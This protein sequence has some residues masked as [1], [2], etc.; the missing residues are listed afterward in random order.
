LYG[1]LEFLFPGDLEAPGWKALMERD[2]FRI[3]STPS[4]R[5]LNETR[6]LVAAHHG[7]EA[8]VYQPFLDLYQPHVT[9]VSDR[10]K[11]QYTAYD[12]Y[13]DASSG[14]RVYNKRTDEYETRYVISTKINDY[15]RVVADSTQ[16]NVRIPG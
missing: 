13:F 16:V 12:T 1:N 14:L 5:N 11:S 4:S 8:G 10:G 6:I 2:K 3:L 9:L 7:R 15:I